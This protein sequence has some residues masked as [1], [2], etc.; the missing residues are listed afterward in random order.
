MLTGSDLKPLEGVRILD[1]SLYAPGPFCSLL[2]RQLGAEVVKIE[3][4]TGD[5]LGT[6]DPEAY[7]RLNEGKLVRRLDLRTA[8]GRASLEDQIRSVD[9]FIEGFRPGVMARLGFDYGKVS[10]LAP[11]IVYVSITG[12]GQTGPDRDRSGH[13][14]TYM[15]LAGALARATEPPVV[16][17]ADFAAGGLYGVIAVLSAVMER[18][19]RGRGRAIDL[20]MYDGLRSMMVLSRGPVGER[21]SGRYPDYAIYPTRDGGAVAVAALE[22]KF[23]VRFCR[24]MQRE[25]WVERQEDPTLHEEV[26]RRIGSED[27]SSWE[28]R[29]RSVDACVEVVHAPEEA[30]ARL[31]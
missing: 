15:A 21:L 25:D 4:P 31:C 28:I 24:A 2:C 22:R 13:D 29:F 9:V 1:M 11:R 6:L 10:R 3:P 7:R 23:W 27:R 19:R 30:K 18:E 12:F 14:L 16:Q 17:V 8:T 5:P 20:S 26:A